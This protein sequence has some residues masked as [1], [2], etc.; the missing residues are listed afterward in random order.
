MRL[1]SN[2]TLLQLNFMNMICRL[3]KIEPGFNALNDLVSLQQKEYFKKKEVHAN[4]MSSVL[5]AFAPNS[6][7]N[8]LIKNDRR[9]T[10]LVD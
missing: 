1:K 8:R 2:E 3:W 6:S 4:D 5:R 7:V 9:T 10:R